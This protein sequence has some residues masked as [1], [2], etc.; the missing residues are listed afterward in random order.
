MAEKNNGWEKRAR[1]ETTLNRT[2]DIKI[3]TK[4]ANE[5]TKQRVRWRLEF[6]K[7]KEQQVHSF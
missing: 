5:L 6:S 2:K 1:K 3:E 4:Y 7:Q